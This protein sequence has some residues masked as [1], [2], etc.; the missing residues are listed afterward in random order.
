[1]FPVFTSFLNLPVLGIQ[2]IVPSNSAWGLTIGQR[3]IKHSSY[4]I[5]FYL[6]S[7]YL[8]LFCPASSDDSLSTVLL[9]WELNRGLVV[10]MPGA[11]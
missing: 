8:L 2:V 3:F 7:V 1:M 5:T 6:F 11:Q 10:T 4:P 9:P